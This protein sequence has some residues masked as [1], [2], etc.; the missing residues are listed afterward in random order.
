M[1]G[2]QVHKRTAEA[3]LPLKWWPQNG[4]REDDFS[5]V[6]GRRGKTAGC[7]TLEAESA[8]WVE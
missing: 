3:V 8:K 2:A 6:V 7:A 1:E 5:E 4:A